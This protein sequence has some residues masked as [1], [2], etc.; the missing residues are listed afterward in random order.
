ML[1]V[2][3]FLLLIAILPTYNFIRSGGELLQKLALFG[4]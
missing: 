3:I 4:H 2:A 1:R